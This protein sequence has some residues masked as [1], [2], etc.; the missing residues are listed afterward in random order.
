MYFIA[1]SFSEWSPIRQT[2]S[3]EID[4]SARS[5]GSGGANCD[6]GVVDHQLGLVVA[7]LGVELE[8]G[9]RVAI[10][11]AIALV[12]LANVTLIEPRDAEVQRAD[13]CRRRLGLLAD[14]EREPVDGKRVGERGRFEIDVQAIGEVGRRRAVDRPAPGQ[15]G[16]ERQLTMA[17]GT[18]PPHPCALGHPVPIEYDDVLDRPRFAGF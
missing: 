15:A 8:R 7:R 11:L 14:V 10:A 18:A 16:F 17:P 5:R 1:S 2:G 9:G 3:D 13:I 6:A 4:T 12:R